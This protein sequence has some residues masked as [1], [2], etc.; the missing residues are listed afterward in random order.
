M[1]VRFDRRRL[2]DLPAREELLEVLEEAFGAVDPERLV[3]SALRSPPSAVRRSARDRLWILAIGKA[4]LPMARGAAGELGAPLHRGLAVVPYGYGGA[5]EGVRILEAGHPIPDEGSLL[6]ARAVEEM[7]RDVAA[8]DAVLCLISGGASAL[9]AAPPAGV[10]LSDLAQTTEL[11]LRSG[12]PIDQVN[13]VRRHLSAVQGG[14]LARLLRGADVETLVLSDVVGSRLESI[15]SGPTAPDPTT[16]ADA[17]SILR[18]SG[19]W[20]R[21][22]NAVR[23]HLER[24]VRGEVDETAKPGDAAFDRARIEVLADDRTFVQ[25]VSQAGSARGFDVVRLEG[26]LAG[27]ASDVGRR[28][29]R[30]AIDVQRSVSR[31]TLLLGSGETTVTVHGAGRGGRNQQ[32]A[33]SAA[34]GI[35]GREG[36][37]MV[38]LASD[39]A[40]GPTDAAGAIVDGGTV[41]RAAEGGFDPRQ[42]IADNDAYPVLDAACDLLRTGPTRT[43]VADLFVARIEPPR[44]RCASNPRGRTSTP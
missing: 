42:A 16:F 8:G 23:E 7:A 24:G 14:R 44:A 38:F 9:V 41:R 29:A 37:T 36:I 39:G 17:A 26:Q 15:A 33:L 12:I 2:S 31:R 6:A 19:L 13:T 4:A 18:S 10:S 28:L 21:V 40:D 30:R 1:E 22:P 32:A 27:E 3:R 34:C 25:G 20:A 11:L 35:A 5:V 43:N